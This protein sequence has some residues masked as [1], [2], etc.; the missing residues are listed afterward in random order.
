LGYRLRVATCFIHVTSSRANLKIV[1][2]LIQTGKEAF[3]SHETMLHDEQFVI[4]YELLYVLHWLLK[5]EKT[6]LSNLITQAFIKGY[7][8]K[9]KEQDLYSKIQHSDDM[10]NS[11]VNFFNFLEHQI[12]VMNDTQTHKTIMHQDIVKTLDK[13]DPERF[14]YDTIKSTVMATADK[15]KPTKNHDEAKNLF[16]KELL[17]QWNPK[18]EK[19]KGAVLDN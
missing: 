4:S 14:D 10:Q 15:I 17:R 3:M 9:L 6:E 16:L 12:A 8:E 1:G 7:E 13:I 11:I 5:Y 19:N 18:K 2:C